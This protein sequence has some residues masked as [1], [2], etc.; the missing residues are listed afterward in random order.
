MDVVVKSGPLHLR[1][2]TVGKIPEGESMADSRVLLAVHPDPEM[3]GRDSEETVKQEE[4]RLRVVH[5]T[6]EDIPGCMSLLDDFLS[7]NSARLPRPSP[8]VTT[9]RSRSH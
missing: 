6:T 7:C 8:R 3:S 4:A 2:R 1:L 9:R 5:P